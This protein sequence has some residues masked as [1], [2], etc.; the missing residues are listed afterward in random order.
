MKPKI[1]DILA[2]ILEGLSNKISIEEINRYLIESKKY[3][4]HTLGIAFSLLYD[5]ILYNKLNESSSELSKSRSSRFLT[6]EEKEILGTSNYNYIMHLMNVGLITQDILETILEQITLYPENSLTQKE[7]NW[8]VL[9]SI[10]D[11][12]TDVPHGSRVLLY[13]SDSVN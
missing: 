2:K 5:K 9:F 4:N 11:F 7:I 1:V 6:E 3:D 10:V 12:D 8:M 13:T